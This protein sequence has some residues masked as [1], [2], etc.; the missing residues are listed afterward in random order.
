MILDFQ[1]QFMEE[2]CW[3][4][5]SGTKSFD[6]CPSYNKLTGNTTRDEISVSILFRCMHQPI[7]PK[8]LNWLEE[9]GNWL[10]FQHSPSRVGSACLKCENRSQL[11]LFCLITPA[12]IQT[13]IS[14]FEAWGSLHVRCFPYLSTNTTHIS[15]YTKWF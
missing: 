13:P 8:S 10:I 4:V 5:F 9:M 14:T 6:Q 7:Q 3:V 2:I 12:R 15:E 1:D 11:Q